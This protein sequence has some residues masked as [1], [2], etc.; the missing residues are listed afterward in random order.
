[1][2]LFS[3]GKFNIYTWGMMVNLGF[4]VALF[5][6]YL[7]ARRNKMNFFNIFELSILIYSSGILGAWMANFWLQKSA[8]GFMFIGGAIL[9]CVMGAIYSFLKKLKFFELADIVI[10]S[11]SFG[12]FF[13]RI[14]CLMA[15]DHLGSFSSLPWAI[16]GRHP[17]ILYLIINLAVLIALLNSLKYKIKTQGFLF[18]IGVVYYSITRFSLD[19]FRCNDLWM[20]D[21]RYSRLTATQWMLIPIFLISVVFLFR[22]CYIK[23][24][25]NNK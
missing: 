2:I 13:G 1:M 12:M 16:A 11:A 17:V 25:S 24:I 15:N 3:V 6:A 23:K 4:F 21:L 9:A 19:F 5:V 18:L 7:E 10:V 20:C 8:I 14:G 22:I